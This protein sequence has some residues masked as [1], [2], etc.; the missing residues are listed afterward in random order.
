MILRVD[1]GSVAPAYEQLITQLM[2]AV[3]SG[4]LAP[5]TRLPTVRQLAGDLGLAT[6]TVARAYKQ[7]EGDGF[8]A[9]NGRNGTVVATPRAAPDDD[10]VRAAAILFVGAARRAGLDLPGALGA[11]RGTW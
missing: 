2:T 5:G 7:L 1:S 10:E 11:I 8:L 4:T 6:N 9:T 3:R